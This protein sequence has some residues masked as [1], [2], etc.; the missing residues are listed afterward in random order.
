MAES[1]GVTIVTEYQLGL[2]A[3][4]V[5][6]LVAL[7]IRFTGKGL[8]MK[9]QLLGATLALLGCAAGN[10]LTI[11]YFI[12][13]SEGM[14]FWELFTQLNP[15]GIPLLII[16][17]ASGMD[18]IFYGIAVYEG[19]RLSLRQIEPSDIEGVVNPGSIGNTQ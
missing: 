10:L 11:C 16:E 5:G 19:Y 6:I 1:G 15:V 2:M 17:T 3:I 7:T 13:V 9:F 8:S 12:A 14:G 4:G 18:F